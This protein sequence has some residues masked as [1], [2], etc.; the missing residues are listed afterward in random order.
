MN[1]LDHLITIVL[2]VGLPLYAVRSL[3]G[4][5]ARIASGEPGARVRMYW[6]TCRM[7]WVLTAVLLGGWWYAGRTG[8]QLGF[9]VQLTGGFWITFAILVGLCAAM[10][11]QFIRTARSETSRRGAE[12]S[13][14]EA[15]LLMPRNRREL[16]PY[17]VLAVTAGVCEEILYRGF[18]IWYVAQFTG[19]TV[20]GMIAAVAISSIAFGVG[21]L[22]QG[23]VA[24]GK[25][26]GFAAVAGAIYVVS[27][28]LWLA[29]ALH[30][31]TDVAAGLLGIVVLGDD[32]TNAACVE[33]GQP[34]TP[35]PRTPRRSPAP[36]SS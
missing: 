29:I 22:Y 1:L 16:R 32:P 5:K 24:A 23:P 18:L 17:M 25:I 11:V 14:G 8:T 9:S 10:A 21:H 30:V 6:E 34:P 33:R 3:P 4:T 7:Q 36:G 20:P 15:A 31:F 35:K 27:G 28:S 12:S 26:V 2:I 19:T 13:F